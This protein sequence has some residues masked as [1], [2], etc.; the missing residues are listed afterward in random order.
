MNG[1]YINVVSRS[2]TR[3]PYRDRLPCIDLVTA[4][5]LVQYQ[6]DNLRK[7]LGV[8]GVGTHDHR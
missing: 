6:R 7:I 5:E 2:M 3:V 4:Q 1:A 8:L